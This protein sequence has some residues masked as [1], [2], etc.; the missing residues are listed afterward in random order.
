VTLFP[1]QYFEGILSYHNSFT[2]SYGIVVQQMSTIK[3]IFVNKKALVGSMNEW[4]KVNVLLKFVRKRSYNFP[5]T[6]IDSCSLENKYWSNLNLSWEVFE[7][8]EIPELTNFGAWSEQ[9]SRDLDPK[10][11]FD[12]NQ[13]IDDLIGIRG[14]APADESDWKLYRSFL[15]RN[16]NSWKISSISRSYK[17]NKLTDLGSVVDLT[18]LIPLFEKNES[19]KVL[20]IGGGYG[21]LLEAALS[22]KFKFSE[23]HLFDVVPS[24]LALAMEY[25][26]QNGHDIRFADRKGISFFQLSDLA[27]VN[28]HSIDLIVNVESFQEMTQEWVDFWIE[29]INSKTKSGSFFYH[30]NSFSYKNRFTLNLGPHWNLVQEIDSPRHWSSGHRTEI[31]KRE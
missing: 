15:E 2:Q 22:N 12:F 20:E 6:P 14:M 23:W 25:L 27:K 7:S 4:S 17:R 26:V 3:S 13:V 5:R 30:S 8:L 18:L 19:P 24:S 28:D 21:R 1:E 11:D 29:V 9:V 16:P 31:W 10:S